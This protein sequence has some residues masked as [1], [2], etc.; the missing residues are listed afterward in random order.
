MHGHNDG[1]TITTHL[2]STPNSFCYLGTPFDHRHSNFE[3]LLFK[4]T[5]SSDSKNADNQKFLIGINYT[6]DLKTISWNL[7]RHPVFCDN[8]GNNNDIY[9]NFFTTVSDTSDN[10]FRPNP[11]NPLPGYPSYI[12]PQW[13]GWAD[14]YTYGF[15]PVRRPLKS[16]ISSLGA[17]NSNSTHYCHLEQKWMQANNTCSLVLTERTDNQK[18]VKGGE[19]ANNLKF[20]EPIMVKKDRECFNEIA[21]T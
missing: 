16:P 15:N 18:F 12:E 20:I 5:G 11:R 6:G 2:L 17:Y 14:T 21:S 10:N 4:A 8:N 3:C 13:I 1:F 9:D 7:E 19:N